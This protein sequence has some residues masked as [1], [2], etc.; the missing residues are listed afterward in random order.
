MK[1]PISQSFS[2]LIRTGSFLV[3][4]GMGLVSCSKETTE[5]G[6]TAAVNLSVT[7]AAT[8]D[9]QAG[10]SA[11]GPTEEKTDPATVGLFKKSDP[12]LPGL[13]REPYLQLATPNSIRILWRQQIFQQPSVKWG[14]SPGNLDK[15]V[16][17]DKLVQRATKSDDPSISSELALHSAPTKTRQFEATIDGL[18]PNTKYYY[19][20]LN[21]SEVLAAGPSHY[22][23]TLPTPNTDAP[24]LIWVAG[25]GGT[26]GRTQ[27]QVHTAA[28]EWVKKSG[29]ELDMFLH[30]GDMAYQK[31]LDSEFSGRFFKMYAPTIQNTVCWAAMGNHEGITSKGDTGVGPYYD[32]YICPTK[33]EAGGVP[34]SREAYYSFDYGKIHFV[35]LDSCSEA[36]RRSGGLSTLG[37]EMM[38]WL[39]EDLE[40]A[41]S[42]W[43]VAFFHHPPYTKGSHD[44]DSQKDYESIVMRKT[45]MP[46]LESAGLD[47]VLSGHSHIYERSMLIKGA[48]HT[49]STAEGVVLDDG[50]GPYA[51]SPGLND[52]EGSIYVVTGNSGTNLKRLG[53]IPFMKKIILEHGS[54]MLDIKGDTLKGIMVNKEGQESDIFEIKKTAKV[55]PR[56]VLAKVAPAPP[57]PTIKSIRAEGGKGTSLEE[58]GAE[59]SPTLAMPAKVTEIIPPRSIW[60]YFVGDAQKNWYAPEFSD[61][62][63]KEGKTSVGY[64]DDDDQTD[65]EDDMEDKNLS[66]YIRRIF[67]FQADVDA[68]KVGLG[69]RYD[70]GF[71]A[72]LNG[73]EVARRNVEGKDNDAKAPKPHEADKMKFEWIPL[74]EHAHLLKKGKNVLAIQ[75]VNDDL[76]SSDFTLSPMLVHEN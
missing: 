35:V 10:K 45:F 54:V 36:M 17:A 12:I 29:R 5:N 61:A 74:K 8:A 65:V 18:Q 67:N 28:V 58:K 31:G 33:G 9:A 38:A 55:A 76:D 70:D 64:G 71:I 66:L 59:S 60:K 15:T 39:K 7:P 52:G 72:Y 62:E 11:A 16:S 43:L 24:A 47:L 21:G 4:T 53:T 56:Q 49:P 75:G 34:S 57:M 40:K 44:S 25:D 63:W 42:D 37:N 13:T 32:G 46:L 50:D 68:A 3:L 41:K 2:S 51:K 14:T 69:M 30:V 48:T 19:A 73:V 22:F 27:A 1:P 20:V 23:K 6:A 26:G